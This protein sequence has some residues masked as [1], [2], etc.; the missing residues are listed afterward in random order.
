MLDGMSVHICRLEQRRIP[1]VPAPARLRPSSPPSPPRVAV[2]RSLEVTENDARCGV[3]G[4]NAGVRSGRSGRT[5]SAW[6]RPRQ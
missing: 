4:A 5:V 1:T 2:A 3:S 6:S